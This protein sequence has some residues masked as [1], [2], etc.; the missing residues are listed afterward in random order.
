MSEK[1][2]KWNKMDEIKKWWKTP[3]HSF[4]VFI[5]LEFLIVKKDLPK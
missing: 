1:K 4:N 3:S 5:F 2:H